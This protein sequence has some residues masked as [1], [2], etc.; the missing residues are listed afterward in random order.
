MKDK[1]DVDAEYLD[2]MINNFNYAIENNTELCYMG[3]SIIDDDNIKEYWIKKSEWIKTIDLLIN[4]AA[5]IEEYE[6]AAELKKIKEL[7]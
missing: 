7:I 6:Y 4:E 3:Y 1:M 5:E 2:M